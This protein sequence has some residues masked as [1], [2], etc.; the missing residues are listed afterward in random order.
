MLL[1]LRVNPN[2][3][4][5]KHKK[6]IVLTELNKIELGSLWLLQSWKLGGCLALYDP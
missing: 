4:V 3:R 2:G 5:S 6:A 1:L